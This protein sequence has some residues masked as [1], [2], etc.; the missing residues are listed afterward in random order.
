MAELSPIRP[1]ASQRNRAHLPLRNGVGPSSLY[2]PPGAWPLLLDCLAERFPAIPR[3]TWAQRMADGDV[4]DTDGQPLAPDS[5]YRAKTHLYYYRAIEAEP[6]V[7]GEIGIIHRDEHLLVVDKP[8]FLPV[9]PI[10]RYVQETL[11]TRLRQLGGLDDLV[12][13]HRIDRETAGLVLCSVNPVTRDAYTALFREQRITKVYEAVA[14]AR[15]ALS[16]PLRRHSR[17]DI[18]EPFF[19]RR[20][21]PGI[22]NADTTISLLRQAGDL[23]LYEARPLTGRTH[24]IRVHFHAL[25]MPLLNDRLYPDLRILPEDDFSAPLQLLARSLQFDDPLSGEPRHF[26]SRR[27]LLLTRVQP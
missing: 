23:A 7:P 13:L 27:E 19:R 1:P 21:V 18:G 2:L 4:L 24:Q 3:E 17:I 15:P 12:P 6:V 22:A 20:E 26:D 14:T 25:D 5:A 16:Y 9:S 10:G 8:H 11:L